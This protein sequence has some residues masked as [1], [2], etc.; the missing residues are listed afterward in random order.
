MNKS[1]HHL[2]PTGPNWREQIAELQALLDEL[3]P[4]LIEAEAQLAD[5]LATIN[6]FEFKLRAKL[7]PLTRRLAKIEQEVAELRRE[8]RHLEDDWLFSRI[9]SDEPE[10]VGGWRFSREESA[11]ASGDYRYRSEA[12]QPPEEPLAAELLAEIKQ[13]YRQLARRFHPDL[14]LNET[15]RAYRTGIMMAINA[16]YTAGDLE[17][18]KAL[19]HEPDSISQAPATDQALAEA[20][21]REVERCRRRLQEIAREMRK[22]EQHESARIM[23]R[24]ERAATVGRDY[25]SEMAR[26]L[27]LQI[28]EKIAE[29]VILKQRIEEFTLEQEVYDPD[30]FAD[31]VYN[32]GLEEAD[33]DEDPFSPYAGWRRKERPS[34]FDDDEDILDDSD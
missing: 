29:Q 15:D 8:L 4:R 7:E 3:R 25:L 14:A 22:L 9:D 32:I 1:N 2:T 34:W 21:L 31:A 5:Q 10:P 33:L 11:A 13:L 6:A 27:Q 30:S 18:L 26:D 23:Q 16:A 12:V 20:L 28:N 17:R 19:A 24:V